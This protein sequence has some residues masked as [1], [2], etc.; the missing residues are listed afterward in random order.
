MRNK[1][2]LLWQAAF[3]VLFVFH[4]VPGLNFSESLPAESLCHHARSPLP[5]P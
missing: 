2:R 3:S 5:A 1:R 4:F